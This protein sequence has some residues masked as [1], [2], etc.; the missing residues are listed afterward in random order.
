MQELLY[1]SLGGTKIRLSK[2]SSSFFVFMRGYTK[3]D[4]V[5]KLKLCYH[6]S[7]HYL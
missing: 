6:I 7:C 3:N 1:L 4:R 2:S 5:V